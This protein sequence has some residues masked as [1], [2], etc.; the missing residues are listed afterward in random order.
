MEEE[1]IGGNYPPS[2]PACGAFLLILV[3][4]NEQRLAASGSW[5]ALARPGSFDEFSDHPASLTLDSQ[6]TLYVTWSDQLYHYNAGQWQESGSVGI[7]YGCEIALSVD[8]YDTP[9]WAAQDN[10]NFYVK[11]ELG[12]TAFE[13]DGDC[14]PA[15]ANNSAGKPVAV[16]TYGSTLFEATPKEI[17]TKHYFANGQ[18]IA[19]RVNDQ[20]YYIHS[21]HLGSTILVTDQN[22]DE[23]GQVQY[24][25]YSNLIENTLPSD[26]TGCSCLDN[27]PGLC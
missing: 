16:W 25:P 27:Q 9:V 2:P 20:V 23:V 26:L 6:D 1:E 24:D 17:I 3:T 11:G 7:N 21:D 10:V 14:N 13:G 12:Y 5:Q 8:E 15:L 18:R 19:T 22:G 4:P